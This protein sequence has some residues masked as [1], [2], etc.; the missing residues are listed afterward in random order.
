[1]STFE[2]SD[3]K[4]LI[5]RYLTGAKTDI[6]HDQKMGEN[7]VTR[8]I[9]M[10]LSWYIICVIVA[11]NSG[12]VNVND[13]VLNKSYTAMITYTSILSYIAK[14]PSS[15]IEPQKHIKP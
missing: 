6:A 12:N 10:L 1:M 11:M 5:T 7:N 4:I 2:A 9:L 3:F 8:K 15:Y 13:I 14:T